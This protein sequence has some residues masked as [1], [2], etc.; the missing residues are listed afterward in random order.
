MKDKEIMLYSEI[1]EYI[2]KLNNTEKLQEAN[3]LYYKIVSRTYLLYQIKVKDM[4]K[5]KC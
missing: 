2:E 5:K 4:Y 1:L 3:K